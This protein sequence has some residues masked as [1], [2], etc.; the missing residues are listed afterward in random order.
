MLLPLQVTDAQDLLKSFES[1]LCTRLGIGA[2]DMKR[3]TWEVDPENWI[4]IVQ[5]FNLEDN[6]FVE[7]RKILWC[8]IY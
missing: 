5:V 2:Y 8:E 4:V 1:K 6:S 7:E 3:I